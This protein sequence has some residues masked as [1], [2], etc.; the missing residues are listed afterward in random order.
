MNPSRHE[1]PF[2]MIYSL[3]GPVSAFE[4]WW[5]WGVGLHH[6][7]LLFCKIVY[8]LMKFRKSSWPWIG[9]CETAENL[10]QT[11]QLPHHNS[12]KQ[13]DTGA[14]FCKWQCFGSLKKWTV[15]VTSKLPRYFRSSGYSPDG[16]LDIHDQKIWCEYARQCSK[17][18]N[19]SQKKDTS[20]SCS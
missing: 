3:F 12:Q 11:R 18:K 15:S 13:I 16:E 19:R 2:L 20:F 8:S 14:S 6:F 17:W 4:N 7:H 1:I 5:C 10:D 9:N